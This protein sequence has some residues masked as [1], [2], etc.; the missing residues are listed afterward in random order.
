MRIF[1]VVACL[2]AGLLMTPA[3]AAPDFPSRPITIVVPFAAGAI[4]DTVA[5]L[6][7]ER[8]QKTFPAGVV[9][10]NRAGAGGMIGSN[11]VAKAPADGYTLL[12]G[13]DDA[14][15]VLPAVKTLPYDVAKDFVPLFGVATSPFALAVTSA[16]PAKDF[17]G[18][19]EAAKAKPDGIRYASTGAGGVV[20]VGMALLEDLA[21]VKLSHVPYRGMAPAVV[22]VIG[23]HVE[24]V[25]VSPATIAPHV[26]SGK[27]RVLAIADDKR[28]PDLPQVPTG[29][30]LGYPNLLVRSTIGLLAPRGTPPE[31][32]RRLEAEIAAIASDEPFKKRLL[33]LG[34]TPN[35]LPGAEYGKRI[36]DEQAR[37]SALAKRVNLEITQ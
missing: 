20:H 2:A 9:I 23:G 14:L 30:E 24:L 8:L 21:K 1:G 31:V 11:F 7:A 12:L 37:W 10:E 5:R 13:T 27:A 28:H 26:Q 29:S 35:P 36:A 19:I 3:R 25:M 32:S 6:V 22:D 16:F 34:I 18:L 4:N 15:S 17:A 33:E